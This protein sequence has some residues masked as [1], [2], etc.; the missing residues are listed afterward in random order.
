MNTYTIAISKF[1]NIIDKQEGVEDIN[2]YI[3]ACIVNGYL[4]DSFNEPEM[5]FE[6]LDKAFL[7]ESE[8]DI[9]SVLN[10]YSNDGSHFCVVTE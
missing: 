2:T 7:L 5:C 9:Q 8:E 1:T 6:A 10:T 4:K 3:H